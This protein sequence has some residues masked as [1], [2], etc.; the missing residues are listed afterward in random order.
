MSC[1]SYSDVIKALNEACTSVNISYSDT[2][3]S[4]D[5]RIISAI[6]ESEYIQ[7]LKLYLNQ[8]YPTL[9]F[10]YQPSDRFWYDFK[11]HSIPFNLKLTTGGSDN[12]FNKVAILF[13]ISGS[14]IQKKNMNFNEFYS[15]LKKYSKKSI[16]NQFTEYHYLAVNKNSGKFIIKS[17]FDI[18]SYKSNPCNILQINW[19][20]EFLHSNSITPDILV[21]QK[22]NTLLK[23]IQYSIKQSISSM[24]EFANANFD[25]DF[26]C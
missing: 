2:N 11:I 10:E 9:S 3:N 18:H 6:K 16:R 7:K 5:G 4:N 19:N 23:T 26:P 8:S 14:E 17:L 22:I 25:Q 15:L 13:S 12:A 20:T 21:C 1:F 24:Q